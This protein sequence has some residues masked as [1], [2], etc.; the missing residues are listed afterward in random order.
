MPIALLAY[1][2]FLV[3]WSLFSVL[4]AA[5]LPAERD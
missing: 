2:G 3:A 5:S 4:A 1:A